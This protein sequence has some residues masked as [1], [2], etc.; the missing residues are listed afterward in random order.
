MFNL[1]HSQGIDAFNRSEYAQAKKLFLQA[2]AQNPEVPE[3]Y[4]FLGK[5]CFLSDEKKIL[6]FI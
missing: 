2:I 5:A 3:T 4:F 6:F 1:F